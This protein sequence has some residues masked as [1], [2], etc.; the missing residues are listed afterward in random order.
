MARTAL[1]STSAEA[2]IAVAD[3]EYQVQGWLPSKTA[4]RGSNPVKQSGSTP[5]YES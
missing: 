5:V 1:S 4:W 3:L 2:A